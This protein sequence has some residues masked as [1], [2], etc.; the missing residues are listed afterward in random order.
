MAGE[1]KGSKYNN[2][3]YIG[4]RYGRLTVVNIEWPPP[5]N[6]MRWRVRCDCGAEKLVVPYYVAHGKTQSCG[7]LKEELKAKRDSDPLRYRW[8]GIVGGCCDPNHPFYKNNGK[9][10]ISICDEWKDDYTTFRDWALENGWEDGKCI[11]RRDTDGDYTPENCVCCTRAEL[12]KLHDTG[13]KVVYYG[14]KWRL[15]DLCEI[16]GVS[17]NTVRNRLRRGWSVED[18]LDKP[19]QQRRGTGVPA[20]K[21]GLDQSWVVIYRG[22]KW[23]ITALCKWKGIK[24]AT[25]MGRLERGMSLEMAVDTPVGPYHKRKFNKENGEYENT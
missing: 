1:W 21:R 16:K 10:G 19:P 11:A 25:L 8:E 22:E 23:G 15:I 4:K 24:Y 17:L 13:R 14:E 12:A 3:E 5:K 18:A 7:C 20:K 9:R 2:K 6:Y